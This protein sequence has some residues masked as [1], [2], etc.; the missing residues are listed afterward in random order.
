MDER[1]WERWVDKIIREA[2]EE[3]LFDDL[4]GSGRPIN[5]E[6]ESWVDEDWVV[7][8]RLMRQ[9]G[10]AP[11]WIELNR[12]IRDTLQAAR[13]AVRQAWHWR[14]AQVG[15]K[16]EGQRRFVEAEWQ[17]ARAAFVET[18]VELNNKIA[19]FNLKV[20]VKRLQRTKIDVGRE[21]GR[22]GVE[23]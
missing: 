7:A 9:H 16:N 8:F 23:E 2:Q 18:V 17:R 6:D 5:W 12:E 4:P 20:P 14:Q 21:L 22:L 13:A 10:Y 19:D 3:G 11:E 15:H 1:P